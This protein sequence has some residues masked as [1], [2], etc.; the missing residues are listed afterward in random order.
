[1]TRLMKQENS[2]EPILD[3]FPLDNRVSAVLV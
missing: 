2:C 1:M 3:N